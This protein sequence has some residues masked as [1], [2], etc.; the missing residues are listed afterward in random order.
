MIE[1]FD[2]HL[3]EQVDDYI[4][5]LF[6]ARDE[7]LEQALADAD[8][9]GLPPIS[10]SPNQGK[11]LHLLA[12]MARAE[13]ILEVGT[14]GGYSTIWLARALPLHGR[15]VTLELEP[16]NADVA[17]RNVAR[18]GF[19]EVVDVRVGPAADSMRAMVSAK[20][21]AFDVVFIDANKEA[22]PE[23]LGLALGLVRTGSLI[24]AD[25]VVRGGGVLD[26]EST[27]PLVRGVREFSQAIATH[28][29]LA[30]LILPIMRNKF[31]GMSISVVS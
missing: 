7:V 23:Y 16:V 27:D 1:P 20:E 26:P 9:A 11:L 24:L 17:R 10:V 14:L 19:G 4:E 21:P 8:A 3:A 13:R 6:V 15:L 28:P 12:R 22:Y 31:D 5:H 25:N 2:Q 18:A 29:R 30:S